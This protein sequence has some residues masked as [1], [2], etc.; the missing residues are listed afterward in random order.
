M[1][2]NTG[3]KWSSNKYTCES[4]ILKGSQ[5]NLMPWIFGSKNHLF[6]FTRCTIV[7]NALSGV[8]HWDIKSI[9]PG[10]M[11]ACQC[12]WYHNR[13]GH[14]E[15]NDYQ[16]HQQSVLILNTL[17]QMGRCQGIKGVCA[18]IL[19]I[20]WYSLTL[21]VSF[22]I[23]RIKLSWMIWCRNNGAI[24]CIINLITNLCSN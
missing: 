2:S 16:Y 9:K 10:F 14:A 23:Y 1:D 15:I 18:K 7:L 8:F 5:S 22:L 13:V 20:C 19:N 12:S 3:G 11:S 21:N 17:N 6:G 4:L 24:K